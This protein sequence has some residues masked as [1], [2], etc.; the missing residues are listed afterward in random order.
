M[1][2]SSQ[3][4]SLPLCQILSVFWMA[5]EAPFESAFLKYYSRGFDGSR[6]RLSVP[7]SI[8]S[9]CGGNGRKSPFLA[10]DARNG[11]P[12]KGEQPGTPRRSPSVRQSSSSASLSG[13]MGKAVKH[14]VGLVKQ[15]GAYFVP[16]TGTNFC[17]G[18]LK[19]KKS[20]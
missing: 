9:S 11:A 6:S 20:Y 12:G 2:A 15:A 7:S 8:F 19:L 5:I 17:G 1:V 16:V 13:A 3:L 14:P 4:M 18:L 10:K